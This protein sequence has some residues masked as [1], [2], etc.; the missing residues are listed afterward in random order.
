MSKKITYLVVATF[1]ILLIWI[2]HNTT[3]VV[4]QLETQIQTINQ[5]YNRLSEEAIKLSKRIT[6]DD[7]WFSFD[8]NLDDDA[9]SF[10]EKAN[11]YLDRRDIEIKP[12]KVPKSVVSK[13]NIYDKDGR[14]LVD[15]NST[16]LSQDMVVYFYDEAGDVA[17]KIVIL[18]SG[19]TLT[20]SYKYNKDHL[21]IEEI[22]NDGFSIKYKYNSKQ[23]CVEQIWSDGESVKLTYNSSGQEIK[24]EWYVDGKW[25]LTEEYT[26]DVDGSSGKI[27]KT[28]ATSPS[29]EGENIKTITIY[30]YTSYGDLAMRTVM[31]EDGTVIEVESMYS[32]Y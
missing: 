10:I 31:D 23:Q 17:G 19:K 6:S 27:I 9:V 13:E 21:C 26:Y 1:L 4:T 22:G 16:N 7:I 8:Q 3:K 2:R 11:D 14:L 15:Y 25:D 28:V 29:E 18:S 24:E 32:D 12:E 30:E 5:E 20:T